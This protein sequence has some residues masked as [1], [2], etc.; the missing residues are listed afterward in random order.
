VVYVV[1]YGIVAK[2]GICGADSKDRRIMRIFGTTKWYIRSKSRYAI[3]VEIASQ[4][5]KKNYGIK[6]ENIRVVD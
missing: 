3:L 6:V 2:R 4:K 5:E 1:F